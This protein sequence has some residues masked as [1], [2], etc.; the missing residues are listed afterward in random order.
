M[1]TVMDKKANTVLPRKTDV[2]NSKMG[3]NGCV[4]QQLVDSVKR[5]RY[6]LH[7][8]KNVMELPLYFALGM[9]FIENYRCFSTQYLKLLNDNDV[10][11]EAIRIV[12][13]LTNKLLETVDNYLNGKVASSYKS[14]GEAMEPIINILP[15]KNI[16]NKTFYRMRS[17]CGLKDKKDFWHI[18]FNKIH[19]SKSERFSIE[20][21]P[22]LYLGYSKR[23]C[24]LEITNGSL[25]K[26]TQ[27]KTLEQILDLTLGQGDG[28]EDILEIDLV[29]VYPLIASCYIVPFYSALLGKECRPDT[30]FFREE[31]IIPQLLT[32][33]LK[34]K[35]LANGII[36]YSVKDPN[37]DI[38][39]NGENDLRNLVLFTNK[40]NITDEM[41]DEELMDYFDISL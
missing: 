33:Y 11:S 4:F 32:L 38:H 26:F 35:G 2:P 10:E 40:K 9:S 23:V 7:S 27:I 29:K 3:N 13:E 15:I 34:E 41:Y 22:C 37:L 24:E 36:Y 28:K 19:L 8:G 1:I 16:D 17:E 12:E 39:G 5:I 21:Y 18:P 6:P 25:A 31:Y 30:S 20:G 14:F